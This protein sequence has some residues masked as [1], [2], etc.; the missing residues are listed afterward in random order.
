MLYNRRSLHDP[1]T[2]ETAHG[3]PRRRTELP[4]FHLAERLAGMS[5][6]RPVLS[7]KFP[8]TIKR[9]VETKEK[10]HA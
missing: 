9:N 4:S 2:A 10:R 5:R 6:T 1:K 3:N 8:M 7:D